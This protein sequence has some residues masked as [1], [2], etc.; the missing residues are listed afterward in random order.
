[1]TVTMT[2]EQVVDAIATVLGT[3]AEWGADH[4]DAIT[5]LIA[6]VRPHP[7][8][9]RPLEYAA[10]FAISTG[11]ALVSAWA[12][13]SYWDAMAAARRASE[14]DS[15]NDNENDNENDSQKEDQG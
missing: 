8:D 2:D 9:R 3:S 4:L 11:R 7:G 13:Q 1:M 15:E 10:D 14:T 5:T 12:D 6:G